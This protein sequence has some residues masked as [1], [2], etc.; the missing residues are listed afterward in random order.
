MYIVYRISYDT[1]VLERGDNIIAIYARKNGA[2]KR[3]VTLADN[4]RGELFAVGILPEGMKPV[5]ANIKE[6]I[7]CV[8]FPEKEAQNVPAQ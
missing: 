1:R 2:N 4:N 5:F 8:S 3:A 7:T 6:V